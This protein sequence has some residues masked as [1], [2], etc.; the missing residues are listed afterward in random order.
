MTSNPAYQ[1]QQKSSE[2]ILNL[3]VFDILVLYQP[4]KQQTSKML[5]NELSSK[6]KLKQK[7]H[8]QSPLGLI[9]LTKNLYTRKRN[10]LQ[11]YILSPKIREEIKALVLVILVEIVLVPL[12]NQVLVLLVVLVPV[13]LAQIAHVM[14]NP[15]PSLGKAPSYQLIQSRLVL[16]QLF[17]FAMC[18]I[19]L[20][21]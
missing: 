8:L 20:S 11:Y 5:L 14:L 7:L 1:I 10:G 3:G 17:L 13:I 6:L 15:R 4:P 19:L 21:V 9:L 16:F 18:L 12:V 2:S